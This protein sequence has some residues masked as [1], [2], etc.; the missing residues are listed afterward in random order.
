ERHRPREQEAHLEIEDDEQDGDEVEAHV[1]FHARI[2]EGVEPALVRGELLG[3]RALVGDHEG[4]DQK[5]QAD[6]ERDRDEDHQ[7][8]A[9]VQQT[10][11]PRL[12][13]T[14]P[15]RPV[16]G[17]PP[18]GYGPSPGPRKL[19]KAPAKSPLPQLGFVP[20]TKWLLP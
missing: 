5:R 15:L 9:T 17:A 2:V 3:V 6:S 16:S 20:R 4:R 11:L 1:E 8:E 10:P 12:P 19:P 18:P 7:R 14:P 13:P